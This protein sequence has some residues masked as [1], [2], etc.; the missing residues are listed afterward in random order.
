MVFENNRYL[1]G[2][3]IVNS[4]CEIIPL[5]LYCN[6]PRQE[7]KSKEKKRRWGI[8]ERREENKVGRGGKEKRRR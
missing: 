4:N 6:S 5:R 3:I 1:H 8:R 2:A 7:N